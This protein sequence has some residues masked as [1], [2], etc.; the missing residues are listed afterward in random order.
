LVLARVEKP[1]GGQDDIKEMPLQP[2]ALDAL[3]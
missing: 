2:P 1:H 3:I